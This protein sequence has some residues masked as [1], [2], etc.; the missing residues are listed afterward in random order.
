MIEDKQT[1]AAIDKI[2]SRMRAVV[3]ELVG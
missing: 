3:D 2:V 1:T